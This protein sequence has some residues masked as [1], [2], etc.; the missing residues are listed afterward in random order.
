MV[1]TILGLPLP[2]LKIFSAVKCFTFCS[3]RIHLAETVSISWT[4]S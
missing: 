4:I 1:R 2:S 3:N